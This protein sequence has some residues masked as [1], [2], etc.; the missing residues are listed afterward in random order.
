MSRQGGPPYSDGMKPE[1][2]VRVLREREHWYA[3]AMPG[4]PRQRRT[5]LLKVPVPPGWEPIRPFPPL[6]RVARLGTG[7][8]LDPAHTIGVALVEFILDELLDRALELAVANAE[9]LPLKGEPDGLTDI[10]LHDTPR[11]RLVNGH[12]PPTE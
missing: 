2:L 4:L 1:E 7:R 6:M 12:W 8:V 11:L 10:Q 9:A 5:V 3:I